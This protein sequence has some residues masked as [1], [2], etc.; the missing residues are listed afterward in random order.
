MTIAPGQTI[1]AR[2]VIERRGF[3]GRVSFGKEDAGRNLPHGVYVDNIGLNGL[4]IVEGQTEREFY[5]SAADLVPET[6]R[7]FHLRSS[8]AGGQASLPVLLHVKRSK[9]VAA[10]TGR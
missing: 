1:Q 7:F 2:V 6:T 9:Q 5:M 10:G 8:E 4:M 3:E